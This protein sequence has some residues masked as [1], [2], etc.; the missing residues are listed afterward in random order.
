MAQNGARVDED[1]PEHVVIP[2]CLR[3]LG[4]QEVHPHQV[5][6]FRRETLRG[7]NADAVD[8]LGD[9]LAK[10]GLHVALVV[11]SDLVDEA[12][13]GS[14]V[15]VGVLVDDGLELELV[16]KVGLVLVAVKLLLVVEEGSLVARVRAEVIGH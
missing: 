9:D 8:L 12:V 13:L 2:I 14:S 3:N 7:V 5:D 11:R 10:A 15:T 4:A 1:L 16:A 6:A